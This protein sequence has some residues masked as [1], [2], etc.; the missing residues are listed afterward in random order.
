[1]P[2]IITE[3]EKKTPDIANKYGIRSWKNR[4]DF[5]FF[6]LGN[7]TYSKDKKKMLSPMYN[8]D[9]YTWTGY[10]ATSVNGFVN[11]II[12][13]IH[14]DMSSDKLY[15]IEYCKK[16]IEE[17]CDR[18]INLTPILKGMD[19]KNKLG[20]MAYYDIYPR[21]YRVLYQIAYCS[22]F[23]RNDVFME[24]LVKKKDMYLFYAH[25]NDKNLGINCSA[26]YATRMFESPSR[27][28]GKNLIGCLLMNI[29]DSYIYRREYSEDMESRSFKILVN[30]DRNFLLF[31]YFLSILC[32]KG[33]V[34]WAGFAEYKA[35]ENMMSITFKLPKLSDTNK[36]YAEIVEG[37]LAY[38]CCEVL[39]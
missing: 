39:L 28:T 8:A 27:F 14:E 24:F 5:Q 31:D 7:S 4:K 13:M 18:D 10:K 25:P 2:T 29:R 26:F 12:L 35:W 22:M 15:D 23:F 32:L 34:E 11:D 21:W 16:R 36:V 17:I 19:T 6:F 37:L 33:F 9:F 30:G 38:P 3:W 1:M 20:S